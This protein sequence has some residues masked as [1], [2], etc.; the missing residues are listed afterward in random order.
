M[1]ISFP[2]RDGIPQGSPIFVVLFLICYNF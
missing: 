1:S 2:L